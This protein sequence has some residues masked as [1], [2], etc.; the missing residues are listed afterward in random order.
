[1]EIFVKEKPVMT[2]LAIHSAQSEI[3]PSKVSQK[4][5][6]TYSHTINIISE[7]E[8]SGL[9]R[10]SKEGRKRLVMLTDKGEEYA[11]VLE[12]LMEI[13]HE[14]GV[15]LLDPDSSLYFLKNRKDRK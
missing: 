8:D 5:D 3:Y 1:V 11:E 7:L 4:I 14:D 9:V 2:V 15:K 6:S 13:D 12:R 10:T